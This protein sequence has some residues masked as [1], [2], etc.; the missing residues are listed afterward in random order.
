MVDTPDQFFVHMVEDLI[1]FSL[2][3]IKHPLN[4]IPETLA[5]NYFE[6]DDFESDEEGFNSDRSILESNDME[7]N[8]DH[9]EEMVNPPKIINHGWPEM[10]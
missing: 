3:D 5:G 10:L 4:V 1:D 9:N 6:P 2:T 8:N 7:D